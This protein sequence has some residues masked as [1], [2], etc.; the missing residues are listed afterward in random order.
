MW[1]IPMPVYAVVC[2]LVLP[3]LLTGQS[4]FSA[5]SDLP[6]FFFLTGLGGLF[7][8]LSHLL[9]GVWR[10]SLSVGQGNVSDES[11]RAAW[12]PI[13]SRYS[14]ELADVRVAKAEGVLFG[15]SVSGMRPVT[16]NITKVLKEALD[17]VELETA[18]RW[19]L[20]SRKPEYVVPMLRLIVLWGMA[21]VALGLAGRIAPASVLLPLMVLAIGSFELLR[22]F[23][24]RLLQQQ[25]QD[26]LAD[27]F[28]LQAVTDVTAKCFSGAAQSG[29]FGMFAGLAHSSMSKMLKMTS[30]GQ[31]PRTPLS[32]P[33]PTWSRVVGI[34]S[35]ALVAYLLL[36]GSTVAMAVWMLGLPR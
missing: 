17:P 22:W 31:G 20:Y 29:M 3:W 25:V 21:F 5:V 1:N 18:I 16:V 27:G 7:A 24:F 14:L 23:G 13:A 30:Q 34:V 9:L 33:K 28:D 32:P 2:F 10:P 15:M 11:L 36:L 35:I 19:A 4:Q 6:S 12:E 8:A 26:A